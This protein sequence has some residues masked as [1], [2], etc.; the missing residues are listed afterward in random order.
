MKSLIRRGDI[1]GRD[2]LPGKLEGRGER[3]LEGRS[4]PG[5]SDLGKPI[6][7]SEKKSG[8]RQSQSRRMGK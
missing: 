2:R 8:K 7:T 3:P 4:S 1:P 5:I 6:Y